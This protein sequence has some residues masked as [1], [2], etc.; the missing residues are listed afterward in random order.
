[1]LTQLPI[2]NLVAQIQG[3]SSNIKKRLRKFPGT[4]YMCESSN[5]NIP[6]WVSNY[7][8]D[9]P[10]EE[11]LI[12]LFGKLFL[13]NI[14]STQY[15]QALSKIYNILVI[16]KFLQLPDSSKK[17]YG[18]AI[19][20]NC[21]WLTK[22]LIVITPDLQTLLENYL[23][24][25]CQHHPQADKNNLIIKLDKHLNNLKLH[26]VNSTEYRHTYNY[27]TPTIKKLI[28]TLEDNHDPFLEQLQPLIKYWRRIQF[29]DP[30]ILPEKVRPLK[31]FYLQQGLPIWIKTNLKMRVSDLF[32]PNRQPKEPQINEQ[33]ID[34]NKTSATPKPKIDDL[35]EED[36]Y[37]PE[38]QDRVITFLL[39][40]YL[41]H[42]PDGYLASRHVK[43]YPECTYR[44]L[45][46]YFINDGENEQLNQGRFAFPHGKKQEL[47][48][49]FHIP[50][51]K[52]V[53]GDILRHFLPFV[54]ALPLKLGLNQQLLKTA[55]EEDSK[56]TLQKCQKIIKGVEIYNA[57]SLAIE[58]L[59]MF[60]TADEIVNA[61]TNDLEKRGYNVTVPAEL[62]NAT[63]PPSLVFTR[64]SQA[65]TEQT[66]QII[67]IYQIQGCW[68]NSIIE[69]VTE[70]V[71]QQ[72]LV[73]VTQEKTFKFWET[74]CLPRLGNLA[75]EIYK[76]SEN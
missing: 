44:V 45:A 51:Q 56:K 64:I 41:K 20:Q 16:K 42:D 21:K 1:M 6:D 75:R 63:D 8:A 52:L 30:H 53:S 29:F 73:K 71:N 65:A 68:E 62:I 38:N 55:I 9:D 61:V 59:P 76:N 23:E 69:K 72:N 36:F 10:N 27:L 50:Y 47:A 34:E 5:T 40:N 13:H 19:E 60:H 4:V 74:K 11:K 2:G 25:Y 66:G 49:R 33:P 43:G 39:F 32:N 48:E 70:Q 7:Q 46:E 17:D 12:D 22:P 14:D 24:N 28:K 26:P 15:Q 3:K 37:N 31:G 54:A 18:K 67:N 35:T 57:R 58:L